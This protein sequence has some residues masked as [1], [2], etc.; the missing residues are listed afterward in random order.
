MK[1]YTIRI[2]LVKN[3]ISIIHH[4]QQCDKLRSKLTEYKELKGSMHSLARQAYTTLKLSIVW[5]IAAMMLTDGRLTWSICK[6]LLLKDFLLFLLVLTVQSRSVIPYSKSCTC[7]HEMI[8][9]V[10]VVRDCTN[11]KYQCWKWRQS[12]AEPTSKH[13]FGCHLT[14]DF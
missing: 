2:T 12:V 4:H 10:N 11:T 6:H 14:C 13:D 7:W 5:A 3:N 8:V 9:D 1:C